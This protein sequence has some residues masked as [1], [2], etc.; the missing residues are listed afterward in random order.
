MQCGHRTCDSVAKTESGTSKILHIMGPPE[1]GG[2][3]RQDVG[4]WG[5]KLEALRLLAALATGFRKLLQP[6]LPAVLDA[7]WAL[8]TAALPIYQQAAVTSA[9]DL[10][11][12]VRPQACFSHDSSGCICQRGQAMWMHW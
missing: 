9:E 1:S 5:V 10:D 3:L 6:H 8:F 4:G 11:E 2:P 12:E 7:T